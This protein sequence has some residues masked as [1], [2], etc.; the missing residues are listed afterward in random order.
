MFGGLKSKKS[1]SSALLEADKKENAP[2]I[3]GSNIT[4]SPQVLI[5][6]IVKNAQL[7]PNQTALIDSV[8]KRTHTWKQ[9]LIRVDKIAS[10]LLKLLEKNGGRNDGN[11][12][13][14]RTVAVLSLN[15]D[16]YYLLFYACAWAGLILVPVNFRL[17]SEEIVHILRDCNAE[18]LL[19]DE[20]MLNDPQKKV[21]EFKAI[22]KV[23]PIEPSFVP[24]LV[25][26]LGENEE[27]DV[28][29]LLVN[30]SPKAATSDAD[31]VFGIFYTGGTTGKAKGVMLTHANLYCNSLGTLYLNR[32]SRKTKFLHV[33]P[34]FHLADA[35]FVF[36]A[37]ISASLQVFAPRF[38]PGEF[39]NLLATYEINKVACIP[40]MLQMVFANQSV[41]VPPALGTIPIEFCYGGSSM[42]ETTRLLIKKLL[43]NAKFFA[44]FGMTEA[45][46]G[47]AFLSNE[48]HDQL[49][50]KE[51]KSCGQVMPWVSVR[52][53]DPDTGKVLNK[54]HQFGEI[55]AFG[56]NV[57]KGYWNLPE[58]T[59]ATIVD[60]GWLRT[61]DGGWFDENGYLYLG[62]RI[63]DMI[64]TGGENVYSLEVEKAILASNDKIALCAVVG[65]KDDVM[66]EIIV[67]FAQLKDKNASLSFEEFK[68]N[69]RRSNLIGGYKIPKLLVVKQE[70]LPTS[71][72]GKILKSELKKQAE[73]L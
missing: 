51:L 7:Y 19:I 48:D 70:G 13:A 49:S 21:D 32:M 30:G 58:L 72:A 20:P 65:K 40:V 10:S 44:G 29:S 52:I 11:N 42:P 2:T 67:C 47:I 28:A 69:I 57:M 31:S 34:M 68:E 60:G 23:F 54:P 18:A 35:Q 59:K 50:D 17:S 71:G 43:P 46:P 24:L 26:P 25:S 62:D 27:V 12:K 66:G 38:V 41:T 9:V 5:N 61:G 55:Q 1:S 14:M 37:T 36:A 3:V 63:K 6:L 15:S 56:P 64:K 39:L 8:S 53:V 22:L 73:A 4:T 16:L 33:A 45:S